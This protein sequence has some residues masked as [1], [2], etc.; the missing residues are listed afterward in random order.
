MAQVKEI[1]A[2]KEKT[3]LSVENRMFR[4][5]EC[6]HSEVPT[7][8][9]AGWKSRNAGSKRLRK[10]FAQRGKREQISG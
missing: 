10:G 5:T 7:D 9:R 8:K 2:F 3:F 4:R 1:G 6:G